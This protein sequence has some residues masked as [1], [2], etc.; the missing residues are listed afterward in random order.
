MLLQKNKTFSAR[1]QTLLGTEDVENRVQK[2]E[3]AH[4]K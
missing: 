4:L 2:E 3:K 1:K